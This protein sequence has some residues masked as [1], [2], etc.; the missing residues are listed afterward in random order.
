[1]VR[2]CNPVRTSVARGPDKADREAI[3]AIIHR[4]FPWAAV[5]QVAA[6]ANAIVALP[7]EWEEVTLPAMADLTERRFRIFRKRDLDTL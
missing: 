4:F 3:L 7:D 2:R 5:G 6:A 1:M